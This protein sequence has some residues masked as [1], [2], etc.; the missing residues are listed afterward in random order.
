MIALTCHVDMDDISYLDAEERKKAIMDE[1]NNGI[2]MM[3]LGFAM[4]VGNVGWTWKVLGG[5]VAIFGCGGAML[6][7]FLL[8]WPSF[9]RYK[10]MKKIDEELSP[11]DKM[12]Y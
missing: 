9:S 12:T 5:Q 7:C 6:F 2:M 8:A 1:Q 11:W 3:L 10:K 4:G